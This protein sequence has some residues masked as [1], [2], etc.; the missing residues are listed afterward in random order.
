MLFSI[1]SSATLVQCT[2]GICTRSRS[3]C[4]A[5]HAL[6][7]LPRDL[8]AG[9]TAP[10]ANSSSLV[11][12]GHFYGSVA[13]AMNDVERHWRTDKVRPVDHVCHASVFTCTYFAAG[14]ADLSGRSTYFKLGRL[15]R[16]STNIN[17]AFVLTFISSFHRAS[18]N[19][20]H[21]W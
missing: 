9:A 12:R 6:T 17:S 16:T 4:H 14:S 5:A 18:E 11:V 15:T 10:C 21:S 13:D 2:A 3:S 20:A 1:W 7:L 19:N 8:P